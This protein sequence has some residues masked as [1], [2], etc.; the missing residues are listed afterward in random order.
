MTE[1]RK[2]SIGDA[3][4]ELI[5]PR[6]CPFCD[7]VVAFG[8]YICPECEKKISPITEPVCRKCGKPIDNERMEY[9][10][11]CSRKKHAYHTGKAVFVYQ[12]AVKESLY[13]FKYANRRE[14]AA[15]YGQQAVMHYGTWIRQCGIEVLVPVPVHKQRRRQRGYNQA[16]LFA[17]EIGRRMNLPVR[18]DLLIRSINTRPQKELDDVQRKKNLKKAFTITQ[19]IVQLKKILLIDD[20]YTTGSTAD[21]VA[22]LLKCAGAETVYVLCVS[23]GRGF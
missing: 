16:E 12:G 14:Y 13:R 18:T 17:R 5:F 4:L 15:F 20:I 2:H 21:A 10:Y 7:E 1:K 6:R 23:I 9:C 22:E 8:E 19:S 11:D 3:C